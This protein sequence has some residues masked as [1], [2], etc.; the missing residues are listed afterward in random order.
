MKK[1][2]LVILFPVFSWALTEG[3]MKS[4]KSDDL[5][6][7]VSACQEDSFLRGCFG[8]DESLCRSAAKKSYDSCF[9]FIES[10]IGNKVSLNEWQK[11]V[12]SCLLRDVGTQWKD[13][14]QQSKACALPPKETL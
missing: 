2:I 1:L 3:E 12:D 14:A 10:R 13:K 11:K 4:L 5:H 6:L 9:K 7:V 8:V